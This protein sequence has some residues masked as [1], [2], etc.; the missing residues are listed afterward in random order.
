MIFFRPLSHPRKSAE[1]FFRLRTETPFF[2]D[3]VRE[4]AERKA[5]SFPFPRYALGVTF[6]F[7][8]LRPE[9]IF[10]PPHRCCC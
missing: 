9:G 8:F 3:L 1:I 5:L 10:P 2:P 6:L 7:F 4:L